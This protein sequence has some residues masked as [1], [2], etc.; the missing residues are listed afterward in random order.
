MMLSQLILIKKII[1]QNS[2]TIIG[3]FSL[4]TTK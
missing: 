1:F 4:I 3:N 2:N